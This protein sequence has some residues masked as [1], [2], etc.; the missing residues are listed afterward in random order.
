MRE[1]SVP[2][3]EAIAAALLPLLL[4]AGLLLAPAR[5]GP[6][7]LP[8]LLQI[9]LIH[10]ALVAPAVGGDRPLWAALALPLALPALAAT[11]Y[12]QERWP[13]AGGL[14]LL[15]ALS[16]AAGRA[17]RTRGVGALYLPTLTL[18]FFAPYA[19]AY[20]VVEFGQPA[21]ADS[22]RRISPLAAAERLSISP[23]CALALLFWPVAAIAAGRR[24][25]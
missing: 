4:V 13:A 22:W 5:P 11:S 8:F 6:G 21:A 2:P 16:G 10:A 25:A 7:P 17:L 9:A 23:L 15:A 3:R 14:L 24:P 1:P 20:L 18:L 19:L 12:G